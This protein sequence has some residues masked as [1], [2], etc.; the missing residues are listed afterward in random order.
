[1][2]KTLSV[3]I[4]TLNRYEYLKR[5]LVQLLLQVERNQDEVELVIC[6]NASKD[7]TDSYMKGLV[8]AHPFIQYHY[9]DEYVE[10]G[11]SLIRS[12]GQAHGEYY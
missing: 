4:P 6:C 11:A 8:K 10:V 12:V 1:M 5:T 9:F 3:V 2:G 7:E